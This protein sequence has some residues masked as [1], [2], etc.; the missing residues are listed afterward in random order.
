MILTGPDAIEAMSYVMLYRYSPR[1][2]LVFHDGKRYL[3]ANA[4]HALWMMGKLGWK[5]SECVLEMIPNLRGQ[6]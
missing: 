1:H 6:E 3:C 5:Q 4:D 2:C